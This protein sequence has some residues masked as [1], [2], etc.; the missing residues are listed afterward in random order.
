VL[1]A[2]NTLSTQAGT[3]QEAVNTFLQRV[4]KA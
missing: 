4:A 3:L 1:E 2:T